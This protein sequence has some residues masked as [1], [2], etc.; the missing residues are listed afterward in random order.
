MAVR[1]SV[2]SFITTIIALIL[3]LGTTI[4]LIVVWSSLP[5]QIP[6]HFN[7]AGE[8]TRWDSKG[9]LLV[10]PI[11]AWVMFIGMSL[12]ERFPRLWNTGVKVTEENKFRI[13][14]LLRNMICAI[15]L[16][17]VAAFMFISIFQSLAI[18]LPAW[19]LPVFMGLLL[20]TIIFFIVGLV[21]AR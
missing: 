15:K 3:L 5:D 9:T 21:R 1:H 19:F 20:L 2:F 11:I 6:G 14:R 18:G 10:L 17:I 16:I 8:V 7:A 4:Y 13:F 12:I